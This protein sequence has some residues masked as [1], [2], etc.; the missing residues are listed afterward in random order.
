MQ[1]PQLQDN[2]KIGIY[3]IGLIG[4][5]IYKALIKNGGAQVFACTS[6]TDT[7]NQLQKSGANVSQSPESLSL[8][9]VIFVC[10]PIS[11]TADVIKQLFN[12]N[13]N[14][15]YVDV[16]SLKSEIVSEIEKLEGCRFIGSH[17]MAGTENSGYSASFAELFEDAV[18]V[19][20]PLNNTDDKDI[21]LL[22]LFITLMGA[23]PVVMDAVEHDMAVA[24]ISHLPML[25]SQSLMLSF[26]DDK[27]AMKL[28]SSGFRDTTRLALSNKIMAK[29]M[30][31]MNRDNIRHALETVIKNAQELLKDEVFDEKIDVI[32]SS[33]AKLY[34]ASGKNNFT[35]NNG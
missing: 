16:A 22:K 21:N 33:R 1:M 28:A 35:E 29:D 9:D 34:N 27:Q 3:S 8:C 15:L 11:K 20:T 19:M 10:S 14:A 31:S 4:G 17:P 7:Y 12:I 5:S 18:W 13:K 2:F 23:K 30:L 6:N 26:K 32:I 24:E 25:I